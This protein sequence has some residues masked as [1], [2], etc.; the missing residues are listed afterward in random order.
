MSSCV[1]NVRN[2][3]YADSVPCAYTHTS[4]HKIKIT[5][6]DLQ[7]IQFLKQFEQC[8]LWVHLRVISGWA[9]LLEKDRSEGKINLLTFL[10]NTGSQSHRLVS[11]VIY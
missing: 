1:Y 6:Y 3:L 4:Y 2:V 7:G 5:P 10:S 9:C 8:E 11:R